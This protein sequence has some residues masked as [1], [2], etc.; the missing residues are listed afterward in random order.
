VIVILLPTDFKLAGYIASTLIGMRSI[1][2]VIV[3][4]NLQLFHTNILKRSIEVVNYSHNTDLLFPDKLID[5][6]EFSYTVVV[7]ITSNRFVTIKGQIYSPEL[8]LLDIVANRQNA[9]IIRSIF[10]EL[11]NEHFT[12]VLYGNTSDMIAYTSSVSSRNY[13]PVIKPLVTFQRD[14][15][16]A[17][18]KNPPQ[19]AFLNYIMKPFDYTTWSLMLLSTLAAAI[20][21]KL[22]R[23]MEHGNS[24]LYFAYG[25]MAS[26]LL[27]SIPFRRN[28][29]M[30][31][32]MLQ[33]FIFMVLILG[34]AFQGLMIS[35]LTDPRIGHQIK[36]VQEL[37]DSDIML[38][39]DVA[40]Y[41]IL[42][43]NNPKYLHKCIPLEH[44]LDTE[45]YLL[46]FRVRMTTEED[47]NHAMIVLCSTIDQLLL[48]KLDHG[49][50]SDHYYLLPEKLYTF[51]ENILTSRRSPF[52]DRLNELSLKIFESGI[53]QFYS[54]MLGKLEHSDGTLAKLND[55]V[56]G[57]KEITGAFRVY[58]VGLAV[59]FVAFICEILWRFLKRKI[60]EYLQKKSCRV[61]AFNR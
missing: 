48:T 1:N 40:Y 24:P 46:Q 22:L 54:R 53:K 29:F 38:Y 25:V 16:C 50:A 35:V 56:L 44:W 19:R 49:K 59:A 11:T 17:L 57:F 5:M 61:F 20:V 52:V 3:M 47:Q 9:K 36:N 37:F 27:Q 23:N 7:Y 33:V 45:D 2:N 14:G 41:S 26:F 34:N 30:Q 60:E 6:K 39:C 42:Q 58:F 28:R 15:Y 4:S 18:I 32:A 12:N 51:Y 55:N 31:V 21:W 8:I 43:N 13:Y 10:S